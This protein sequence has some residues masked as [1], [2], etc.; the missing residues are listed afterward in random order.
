MARCAWR[1]SSGASTAAELR[2][3]PRPC[4]TP[5][6]RARP[7]P[8]R[9]LKGRQALHR[10]RGRQGLPLPRA[11]GRRLRRRRADDVRPRARPH[12]R[13]AGQARGH[14]RLPHR[15][16][17]RPR[18]ERVLGE[19]GA[20]MLGQTEE[21][22]PADRRLYA[23]RDVTATV[24]SIP[25]IAASILSKKLAEDL[26]GLVLDVKVGSG[27]FM[28]TARPPSGSRAPW[29]SSRAT[30]AARRWPGSP[31]WTRRSAARWATP[32]SC[33]RRWRCSAAGGRA[34]LR[35][36]TLRLG[37][38]D[39]GARTAGGERRRGASGG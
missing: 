11:A 29:W 35:A 18:R 8:T 21:L 19:L 15:P 2:R 39:A 38:R 33:S 31:R 36:L 16:L 26:D 24:E 9:R 30:W 17:A 28:R 10:R 5:G 27:A 22:A 20:C 13:H 23:L 7:R 25:L 14:P 32:T 3:S 37:R 34:D 1:S 6:E 12:R 4:S